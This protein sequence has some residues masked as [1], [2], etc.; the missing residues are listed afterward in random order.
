MCTIQAAEQGAVI[1]LKWKSHDAT[2]IHLT[3]CCF[4]WR[5]MWAVWVA[6]VN[7]RLLVSS[8]HA[9]NEKQKVQLTMIHLSCFIFFLSMLP[10]S[11]WLFVDFVAV[12]ALFWHKQ[13]NIISSPSSSFLFFFFNIDESICVYNTVVGCVT[14]CLVYNDDNDNGEAH[15]SNI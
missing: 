9:S 5:L 4:R 10:N 1:Y 6:M 8:K 12:L 7:I 11:V 14:K 13:F 3:C 15:I 2:V